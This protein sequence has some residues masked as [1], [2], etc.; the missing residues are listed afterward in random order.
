VTTAGGQLVWVQLFAPEAA[1][2]VQVA[3]GTL[4]AKLLTQVVAVQLFA[5]LATSPVHE[6]T[7]TLVVTLLPHSVAV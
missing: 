3:T 2:A 7:G 4:K 6:A 1:A 5:P